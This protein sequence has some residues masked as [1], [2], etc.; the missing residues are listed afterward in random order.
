M[1]WPTAGITSLIV[2]FEQTKLFGGF[3]YQVL[4]KQTSRPR[5]SPGNEPAL[6]SSGLQPVTSPH[7]AV[8]GST[9]A[10]VNGI[11]CYIG[12][13]QTTLAASKKQN[14]QVQTLTDYGNILSQ[15]ESSHVQIWTRF[16]PL[17]SFS[18]CL[19]ITPS[20]PP[21]VSAVILEVVVRLNAVLCL[22]G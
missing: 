3:K 8:D 22:K 7:V 4:K 5:K 20:T 21:P 13:Q 16:H 12:R 17:L 10:A 19:V 9:K 15:A 1:I 2:S 14:L 6:S 18:F 11:L